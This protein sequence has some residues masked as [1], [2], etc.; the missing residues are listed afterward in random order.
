MKKESYIKEKE[1]AN[2]PQAIDT[3]EMSNLLDLMK[4]HI[5]KIKCKDGSHGTGFFCNI[6]NDWNNIIK[7]LMTN[8]HELN[9]NDIQPGQT[10]NFSIN[11][12]DKEYNILIDIE[13]MIYTNELYDVTIIEIKIY[14]KIEEKSFFDLDERIFEEN[15]D[16]TLKNSQIF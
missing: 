7:V 11:N 13:R 3:E 6:L 10:I 16:K 1:I 4:T 5:C 15:F 2:Q 9:I 12:D 8:N 14:D